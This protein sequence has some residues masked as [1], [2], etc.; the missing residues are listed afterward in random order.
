MTGWCDFSN[1]KLTKMLRFFSVAEAEG[2]IH[3]SL[4]ANIS[5]LPALFARRA[6]SD[7]DSEASRRPI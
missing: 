2:L 1:I 7:V 4:R 6:N 3:P 5:V